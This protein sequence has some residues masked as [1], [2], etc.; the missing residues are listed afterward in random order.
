MRSA[1][2]DCKCRLGA[3]DG[4]GKIKVD[5]CFSRLYF[6]PV[7]RELTSLLLIL[8]TALLPGGAAVGA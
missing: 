1:R 7:N 3:N 4:R 5:R 8:A 2:V 6:S